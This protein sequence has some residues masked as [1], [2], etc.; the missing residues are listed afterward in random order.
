MNAKVEQFCALTAKH[1][2]KTNQV[3]STHKSELLCPEARQTS[4]QR[5]A[6][7]SRRLAVFPTWWKSVLPPLM[8][9]NTGFLTILGPAARMPCMAAEHTWRG[10]ECTR[11]S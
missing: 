10:D 5:P 1:P 11:D 3:H 4:S 8:L 7:L 6:A 9:A 2:G